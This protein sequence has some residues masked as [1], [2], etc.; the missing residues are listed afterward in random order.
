M[1]ST[2]NSQEEREGPH[3]ARFH[4]GCVTDVHVHVQS[5]NILLCISAAGW[6]NS[7]S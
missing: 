2:L 1:E 5:L 4:A 6:K 3:A 7:G